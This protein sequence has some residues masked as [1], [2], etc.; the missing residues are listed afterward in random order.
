[1]VPEASLVERFAADLDALSAPG[2]RL[3]IAVSGGPDSLAL[4]L[5][6]NAARPGLVE[7]ATVDHGVRPEAQDE[8]VMVANLCQRLD[9]PHSTLQ[10]SDIA[11]G[12]G[13]LQARAREGRYRLLAEWAERRKLTGVATAHHLDDQAETVLMRLSRGSGVGGLAGVQAS[14]PLASGVALVRPLLGWR[15]EQLHRVVGE[16]GIEPALDP[17]NVDERFDRTRAR[18]LLASI[19]WLDPERLAAVASHS[20]DADRALEWAA[21]ENFEQRASRD[22]E[23]LLLD[24]TGLPREI[25]RRLLV[26]AIAELG[27]EEP[28]G[29]QLMAAIKALEDA[30]VT[31]LAGLKLEGGMHWRLSVAPPRRTTA[32]TR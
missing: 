25:K 4:L 16:A 29:P 7:A 30:E 9:I 31:T 24:P 10:L 8:A 22:G 12:E 15:R 17:S 18:D 3:G 14:R 1:M 5:L 2:E 32:F 26:A 19:D 11:A 23:A 28:P 6:A 13:N 21:Q 20:R 27:G